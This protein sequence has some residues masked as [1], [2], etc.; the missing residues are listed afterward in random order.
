MKIH[1]LIL[2]SNAKQAAV[3]LCPPM[4]SNNLDYL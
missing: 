2:L 1:A 3:A 4:L